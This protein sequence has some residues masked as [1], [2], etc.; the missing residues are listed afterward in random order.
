MA[1]LGKRLYIEAGSHEPPSVGGSCDP[2]RGWLGMRLETKLAGP[3]MRLETKTK[4]GW[5]LRAA[6]PLDLYCQT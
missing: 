4:E 5:R 1:G 2:D 3:G 6:H